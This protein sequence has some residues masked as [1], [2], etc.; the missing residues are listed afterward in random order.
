MARKRGHLT[1]D[2]PLHHP[3]HSRPVTRREFIARGLRAGLGV[4]FGTSALS[5]F[6]YPRAAWAALSS[7]LETLKPGCGI[8]TQGAGKIPFICFDLA[9]GANIAGSNALVG[10]QG[11]QFDFRTTSGYGRLGLPGN[12]VPGAGAGNFINTDLGI[13]FHS[14]SAFLRGILE[15]AGGRAPSVNGALIPARSDDD[16]GNNPH[17]PMYGI[18]RSGADGSLVTLVGSRSSDSGGTRWRRPG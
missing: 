15:K 7:D 11:G 3:D 13:A 17:N 16:T 14:D 2:E 8:A 6:A 10:G 12:M 5:L 1:P 9:G 4:A 18:Y